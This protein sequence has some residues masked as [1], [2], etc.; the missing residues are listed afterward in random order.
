MRYVFNG[1]DDAP[2]NGNATRVHVTDGVRYRIQQRG[3]QLDA[4]AGAAGAGPIVNVTP[5]NSGLTHYADAVGNLCGTLDALPP[6]SGPV[7]PITFAFTGT[8]TEVPPAVI[9]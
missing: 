9:Q 5:Q 6:D 3:Q 4:L 2:A 8:A 7:V 1:F